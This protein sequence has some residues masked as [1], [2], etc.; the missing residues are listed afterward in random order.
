MQ[1]QMEWG[2]CSGG[3]ILFDLEMTDFLF[4]GKYKLVESRFSNLA[5]FELSSLC[6]VLYNEFS[7]CV[8]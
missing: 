4:V 7:Q 5:H 3:V 8:W 2:F 6:G 1:K